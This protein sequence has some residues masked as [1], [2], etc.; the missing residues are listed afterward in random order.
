MQ[1]TGAAVSVGLIYCLAGFL[2]PAAGAE[3]RHSHAHVHGAAEVNIAVEGKKVTIELRTASE[4]VMGF[5]HEAKSDADKKKRDAA[6][7]RVEEK[8]GEMI[9]LDKKLGCKSQG[10]NVTLVQTDEKGGKDAKSGAKSG[11]HREVRARYQYECDKAPAGSRVKFGITKVFPAI[12]DVKVQVLADAK[13]S[14]ATI[15]KDRGD[16]GL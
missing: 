12:R 7:K 9:V 13:Q 1:L 15:K 2:N 6:L 8:F 3:K 11:E 16:V 5:E 10:G 4:G 14:G